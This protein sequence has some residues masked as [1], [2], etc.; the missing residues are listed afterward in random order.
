MII[1]QPCEKWVLNL[2]I[3]YDEFREVFEQ[4]TKSKKI[5]SSMF[6]SPVGRHKPIQTFS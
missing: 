6:A 4:L 1:L 5:L 2:R 3:M